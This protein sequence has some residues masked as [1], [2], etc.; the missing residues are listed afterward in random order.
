AS[1]CSDP[2]E[3]RVPAGVEPLTPSPISAQAGAS[4]QLAV[5]VTDDRGDPMPGVAVSWTVVSGGGTIS[6]G[7]SGQ[8]GRAEAVWVLG[9]QAGEQ[10][11]QATVNG[12][13]SALF[14][15]DAEP[16]DVP[17]V[18]AIQPAVLRPGITA[19][20][21]GGGFTAAQAGNTV[22]VAGVAATVTA[23]S[24]TELT[25]VVPARD[26]LPCQ[27]TQPVP[28]VVTVAG[29]SGSRDHPLEVATRHSLA[30]GESLLL[31][32][33][34]EVHCNELVDDGARYLIGV[35][36]TSTVL[37]STSAFRL[38]GASAATTAAEYAPAIA[39]ADAPAPPSRAAAATAARQA[40]PRLLASGPQDELHRALRERAVAHERM[41]E[42]NLDMLRR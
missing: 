17:V 20:I 1:A 34:D 7:A 22:T 24:P 40:S 33:A 42:R 29:L 9:V 16:L 41:L 39:D 30:P 37:N 38:R 28:V 26:R 8:D 21:T 25:I 14:T 31:L 2:D 12:A 18:S 32:D 19:T 3:P 10:R 13:G 23:A 11:A 15:A 4:V 6:G 35:I 5:Q 27:P 36:N